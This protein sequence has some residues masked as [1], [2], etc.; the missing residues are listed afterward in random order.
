M[1]PEVSLLCPQ[2]PA[3]GSYPEPDKSRPQPPNFFH[4]DP[5]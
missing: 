3:T 4:Q 5:F 1:E 2:D